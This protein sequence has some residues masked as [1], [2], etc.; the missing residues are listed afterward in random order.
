MARHPILDGLAVPNPWL[1]KNNHGG[2]EGCDGKPID[3]WKSNSFSLFVG[4]AVVVVR[5]FDKFM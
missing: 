3:P 5:Q 2:R 1:H 4:T